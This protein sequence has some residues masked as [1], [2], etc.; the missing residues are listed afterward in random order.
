MSLYVALG[1]KSS[2]FGSR[3]TQYYCKGC[4][5]IVLCKHKSQE[6]RIDKIDLMQVDLPGLRGA[7]E[8]RRRVGKSP[9]SVPRNG[10]G[11]DVR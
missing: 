11:V 3:P 9:E 6:C 8:R 1:S 4:P 10:S 2:P 7:I 5:V